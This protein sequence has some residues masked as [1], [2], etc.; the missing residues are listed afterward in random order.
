MEKLNLPQRKAVETT[1]GPVLVIAGAG[2][3]KT[4]ALTHRVAYLIL[5]KKVRPMNILA[6][7]FTNKAASEMKERITKLLSRA[8]NAPSPEYGRGSNR[9]N[10]PTIGTFHSICVKILRREIE[11]A[12]YKSSF[13]I[14]DSQDQLLLMKKTM[15]EMEINLDQFKPQAVLGAISKAK[16]ELID[17]EHF[18]QTVGGFWEEVVSKIYT[19]YQKRLKDQDALDFDDILMLTVKIFQN[20]PETLAKYQ[21]LFRYIMVDEYQDT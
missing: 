3:G 15:K 14:Y 20:Y 12:G 8:D 11:K 17:A 16:N 7:T 2:S 1:E 13:N 18:S 5:D 10:L 4:R 6:V 19:A 9:Y 21:N